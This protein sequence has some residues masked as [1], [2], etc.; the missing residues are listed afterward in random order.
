MYHHLAHAHADER[1]AG[2][3]DQQFYYKTRKQALGP[4]KCRLWDLPVEVRDAIGSDLERTFVD[5]FTRLR[6]Q[7]TRALVNRLVKPLP[8]TP[9]LTARLAAV[10]V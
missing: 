3:S 1:K 10:F 2:M 5:M 9:P 4:F 6:L 8:T 7:G